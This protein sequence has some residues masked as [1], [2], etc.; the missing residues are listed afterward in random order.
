[1]IS[2]GSCSSPVPGE[3][4]FC[5]SCGAPAGASSTPTRLDRGSGADDRLDGRSGNGGGRF[6]PG[7]VIGERYRIIGL[8]GRG[9]MGEVYR[10]DDLRLGQ[11]VAL[12]FLPASLES[13]PER[14]SRFH[15]EV[16]L[17]RQVSHPNVCRMYDIGETEGQHFLSM[18]YVD[19]EDLE[20]LLR[21]IGRLPG[22][23]AIQ[24]ARQLCAGLAAAHDAGV[25]HRDLK[26]ANVMIDGR[27]R[28]RITDFG[29]AAVSG[30]VSGPEV[31]SGTPD[32]MSP[33][34]LSGRDVTVRSDL[35]ALGLILYET[36]TGKRPFER[37]ETPAAAAHVRESCTLRTPSS[38]HEGI[39]PAVERAILRCLEKEPQRR[40]ASALAVSAALPGGDPLAAALAAGET[41]SPEMV[42]AAGEEGALPARVAWPCLLAAVLGLAL[43]VVLSH[44]R[45]LVNHVPMEKTP[46]VLAERARDVLKGLGYD[47]PAMDSAQA[48]E[49]LAEY[50]RYVRRHDTSPRRWDVLSSGRPAALIFWYRQSPDYLASRGFVS[51]ITQDDPPPIVPGMAMV[52]LDTRGRLIGF[53]AVP[54]GSEPAVATAPPGPMAAPGSIAQPEPTAQEPEP[55]TGSEPDWSSLFAL[56]GLSQSDFEPVPPARVPPVFCDRRAAWKGRLPEL[57]GDPI[58]LEAGSFQ[59]RVASFAIT[60]PWTAEAHTAGGHAEENMRIV[61]VFSAMVAGIVLARRNLRLGRGDRAGALKLMIYFVIVHLIVWALWV[62]HVPDLGREWII[63]TTNTG[64]T[65]F[66][67]AL[68][69]LFYVGLEPYVRRRWPGT[70]IAWSRVLTGRFRDPLVGREILIGSVLG[71]FIVTTVGVGSRAPAWF[72]LPTEVPS[73]NNLV[74]LLGIRSLL[75]TVIDIHVHSLLGVMQGLFLFLLFCGLFRKE[76]LGAAAFTAVFTLAI[77]ADSESLLVLAPFIGVGVLAFTIVI[78][79][80]GLLAGAIGVL[81]PNVITGL[82]T[83]SDLTSWYAAPTLMLLVVL[84]GLALYGFRVAL[85][86]RP[87]LRLMAEE[88]A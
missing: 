38:V 58:R 23:K 76:W 59:G 39:D 66:N 6:V 60:G 29:L 31:R 85:A 12:K 25:L 11:P 75:G 51:V 62:H 21:R 84:G 79:R 24:F 22:D 35:Y 78:R 14:L 13:D 54:Q 34:Q 56:A 82:P 36:F 81:W 16:R 45:V 64:W 28:A 20:S 37:S 74:A 1:M 2:C 8:L 30:R 19:G 15:A 32:Y 70:L 7:S 77:C 55:A 88:A 67:A 80:F 52:R 33:E 5:P 73:G 87:A 44:P 47:A 83:T 53:E 9:G 50:L 4:R 42:A 40:P 27:G 49:D 68:I 46:E 18:E 57:P 86:G 72:G 17:A 65:L 71:A 26:P 43:S 61:L 10:A 69:W 3:A 48:L 41:P 63:F